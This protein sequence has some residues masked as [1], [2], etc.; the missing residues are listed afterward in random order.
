MSM[1]HNYIIEGL[2]YR[3]R[4]VSLKDAEYIIKVRLEDLNR[5]RHIHSIAGKIEDEEKWIKEY[6]GRKGD[7]FFIIENRFTDKPEGTVAIFF[8]KDGSVEWGRWITNKGSFAFLESAYLIYKF[9]FY[10]LKVEE[11]CCRTNAENKPVVSFHDSI[12]SLKRGIRKDYFQINDRRVDACEHY[13][14]RTHFENVMIP[15]FLNKIVKIY[16][17]M[18]RIYLGEFTF[19][20]IGIAV[21]SIDEEISKYLLEGYELNDALF[22]DFEQGIKGQFLAQSGCP[23]IELLENLEGEHTLDPYLK[24]GKKMYHRGYYVGNLEAAIEF[25]KKSRAKVISS[26]K[27]SVYFKKRVCFLVMPNMELI[28]LMERNENDESK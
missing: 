23:R 13:T 22:E 8:E 4:P 10:D 19:D 16:R 20:H 7:Y 12:G 6:L 14:D 21:K 28:E 11:I 5:T 15:I 9:G 2:G 26:P 1:D 27:Q 3:L 17:R 25:L 18:L 24:A